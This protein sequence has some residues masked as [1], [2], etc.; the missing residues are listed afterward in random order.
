MPFSAKTGGIKPMEILTRFNQSLLKIDQ[1]ILSLHTEYKHT[2]Q[3]ISDLTN[4]LNGAI[5]TDA[6]LKE[7]V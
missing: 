3:L 7:A 6:N 2:E 4:L 1:A 5:A